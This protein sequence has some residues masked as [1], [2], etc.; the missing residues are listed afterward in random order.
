MLVHQ[1]TGLRPFRLG[2]PP[3]SSTGRRTI[4]S[5]DPTVRAPI[6]AMES[7]NQAPK[8]ERGAGPAAF[9]VRNMVRVWRTA[10]T[11]S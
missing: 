11:V 8:R 7:A 4:S 1:A 6:V 10:A 2:G 9:S 5:A 3:G